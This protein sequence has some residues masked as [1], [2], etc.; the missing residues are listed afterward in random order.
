MWTGPTPAAV[1]PRAGLQ[2]TVV[3]VARP[4]SGADPQM[5][6]KES[7]GTGVALMDLATT[8][9]VKGDVRAPP[10]ARRIDVC[11]GRGL[12]NCVP[13]DEGSDAQYDRW[14]WGESIGQQF[15]LN[16]NWSSSPS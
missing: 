2:V 16:R 7:F 3:H 14:Q 11:N 13:N 12:V 4:E 9:I 1:V 10:S 8:V 15:G 6:V 5:A